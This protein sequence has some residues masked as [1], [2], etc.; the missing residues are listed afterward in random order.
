MKKFTFPTD[1]SISKQTAYKF[2]I[3]RLFKVIT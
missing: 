3:Y 2:D 1:Y